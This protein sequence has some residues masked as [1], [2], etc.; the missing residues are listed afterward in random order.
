[1]SIDPTV[2]MRQAPQKR[3]RSASGRHLTRG[4]LLRSSFGIA[5]VVAVPEVLAGTRASRAVAAAPRAPG[6][7][8]FFIYGISDP[9]AAPSAQ[10]GV[11]PGVGGGL[12]PVA[13]ELASLP[14]ASP[15][16]TKLA[17][18]AL[19]E[20]GGSAVL[21]V[22][23]VDKGSA[24]V[25]A[26][27]TLPMPH[28]PDAMILV[29]PVFASDNVTVC[30]VLSITVPT[31]RGTGTKLNPNT[32]ETRTVPT[33]RW[34]SHHALAYFD[35]VHRRFVGPFDLGDSPT[36]ARVNVGA[37]ADELFLWT[38]SE[39][40]AQPTGRV[41]DTKLAAYPLG[42]GRA[43]FVVSAPGAW[44]VND[45]PVVDVGN[46]EIARLVN[47]EHLE[48]YATRDGRRRTITIPPFAGGSA[49]PAPASLQIRPDG[50]AFLSKP[51]VG[52]AVVADPLDSFR[53]ISSITFAPPLTAAGGPSGKAVLS[54]DGATLNALGSVE[55]GGISAYDM[56]S[57]SVVTSTAAGTHYTGLYELPSGALLAAKDDPPRLSFFDRSLNALGVAETNLH[58]VEVF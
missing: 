28:L 40:A 22:R 9:T 3:D 38:L 23:V 18:V 10:A 31:A 37:T 20:S 6:Q 16:Q 21:M 27:G 42:S 4:E 29:T 49:K 41:P 30:I 57:G 43:R 1:M 47:G 45:E 52:Q 5:V 54:A 46:G 11:A 34:V 44:P 15:D 48:I 32:G 17:L 50:L 13:T 8:H 56:T 19:Q 55:A 24:A 33:A 14:V 39:P 12:S 53:V 36:L 35:S 26:A 51:V 7:G 58:V 25:V 2:G